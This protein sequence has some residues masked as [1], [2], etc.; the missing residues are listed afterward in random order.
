MC[1]LFIYLVQVQ[2]KLY[3]FD[4]DKRT[5][6]ERGRGILRLNDRRQST[7]ESAIQSRIGEFLCIVNKVGA[8]AARKVRVQIKK[9]AYSIPKIRNFVYSVLT[10]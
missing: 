1:L 4:V 8:R 7:A 3:I 2:C 6:Q 9:N 10:A 5:W